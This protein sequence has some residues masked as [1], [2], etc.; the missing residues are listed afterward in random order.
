MEQSLARRGECAR[1]LHSIGLRS[2]FGGGARVAVYEGMSRSR[3]HVGGRVA[4]PRW[5][6]LFAIACL[7]LGCSKSNSEDTDRARQDLTKAQTLVTEKRHDL[8]VGAN[9]LDR[10]THALDVERQALIAKQ[11]TLAADQ[12]EL[13]SAQ[14]SLAR[15]RETFT[16]AVQVRLA[17]LDVALA[18]LAA[19]TD[20]ASVDASTGLRARRELLS[21]RIAAMPT[22]SSDGWARYTQDI[23]VT[24]DAI[25]RDLQPHR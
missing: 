24:F 23:E 19:A 1:M 20:T 12:R 25:E 6:S 8:T 9:E 5:S 17:K 14:Q 3:V 16:A 7:S 18:H 11:S 15:A 13:G 21:A 2:A 10:R 4:L 22:P